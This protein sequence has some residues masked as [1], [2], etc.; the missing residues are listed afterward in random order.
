MTVDDLTAKSETK[1]SFLEWK[2]NVCKLRQIT[3]VRN[4]N[5]HILRKSDSK[6]PE[7]MKTAAEETVNFQEEKTIIIMK[8]A[9]ILMKGTER[10]F[11]ELAPKINRLIKLWLRRRF[12]INVAQG[13]TPTTDNDEG[14]KKRI[15]SPTTK[16]NT[17]YEI[18]MWPGRQ[19]EK[20]SEPL[21]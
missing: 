18:G 3:E 4:Y 7:R 16:S 11:V 17:E 10:A 6:W 8:V 15:L 19:S 14:K 5:L 13:Y 21:I 12:T 1:I 2:N 20:V 9:I